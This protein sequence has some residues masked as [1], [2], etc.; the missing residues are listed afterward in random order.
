LKLKE[1]VF[2]DTYLRLDEEGDY[3]VKQTPCAFLGEDNA[4]SIYEFRPS[5]CARFPYTDEDVL[6]KRMNITLKNAEFCPAVFY[7]LEKL[8]NS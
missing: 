2:I 3:V 6:L 4:C 5:D 7:V 8:S 1:S